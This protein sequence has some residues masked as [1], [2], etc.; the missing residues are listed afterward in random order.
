LAYCWPNHCLSYL[1]A[2]EEQ[3]QSAGGLRRP[4]TQ[5]TS[6]G[7][8]HYGAAPSLRAFSLSFDDMGF[9]AK[10]VPRPQQ[11]ELGLSVQSVVGAPTAQAAQ[12][13]S[14]ATL[15]MPNIFLSPTASSPFT[16]STSIQQ[17]PA[18]ARG[19][20][21]HEVLGA[22]LKSLGLTSHSGGH[23]WAEDLARRVS[24]DDAACGHVLSTI[25]AFKVSHRL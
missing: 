4:L 10:P 16:A 14:L 5:L 17:P 18:L 21:P 24:M 13:P 12:G 22:A 20:R 8:E 2:V 6:A 19:S 9:L 25:Q 11:A 7:R 23:D 3:K 1:R 15:S